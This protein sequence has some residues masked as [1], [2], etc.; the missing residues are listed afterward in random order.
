[1]MGEALSRS[2]AWRNIGLLRYRAAK[3]QTKWSQHLA[4][5]RKKH[6]ESKAEKLRNEANKGC[7]GKTDDQN[8]LETGDDQGSEEN[9]DDSDESESDVTM[10]DVRGEMKPF[11]FEEMD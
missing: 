5:L 9:S 8:P 1:M 7:S 3:T 6:Q 10:A 11:V 2:K 4:W